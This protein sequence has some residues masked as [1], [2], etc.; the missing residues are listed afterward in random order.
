MPALAV[1]DKMGWGLRAPPVPPV[2]PAVVVLWRRKRSR[3]RRIGDGLGE[4]GC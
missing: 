3:R 2:P 4:D 1:V